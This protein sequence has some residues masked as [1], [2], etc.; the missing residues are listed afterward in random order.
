MYITEKSKLII[1]QLLDNLEPVT[2]TQIA[3]N[4]NI[5]P[6]SVRSYMKEVNKILNSLGYTLIKKPGVGVLLVGGKQARKEIYEKLPIEEAYNLNPVLRKNYIIETLL[7]NRYSYTIQLLADDLQV[8]KG[9]IIKDLAE[10]E[11]WLDKYRLKLIKKTNYGLSIEGSELDIRN[12]MG[13]FNENIL[14]CDKKDLKSG[15]YCDL[16][17]RI[18][19]ELFIKLKN[20]YPNIDIQKIIIIL[21]KAESLIGCSYTEN[22][23]FNLISQTSIAIE[24]VKFKKDFKIEEEKKVILK[25]KVEYGAA[26]WIVEQLNKEFGFNMSEEEACYLTIFML[27]SGI[28]VDLLNCEESLNL[29]EYKYKE[30]AYEIVQLVSSI[31]EINLVNNEILLKGLALH[32]KRVINRKKFNMH[33]KNPLLDQIKK[34]YTSIF[35][36]C[37]ATSNIFEKKTGLL[38][39]EDEV[40]FIA[41]HIGG[42]ISRKKNCINVIVV[43]AS[44]IGTS[45]L[46]AGR[47]ERYVQ[48]IIVK[49]V[50]PYNHLNEDIYNQA[51]LIISTVP[52]DNPEKNVV[53]I[54][55]KVNE[56]DIKKIQQVVFKILGSNIV[57][58][59]NE[60]VVNLIKEELIILDADCESIEDTIYYAS[61]NLYENGYVTSEFANDVIKREKITSTSVGKGV[62]IPH[63]I[64]G[65]V[66]KPGICLIKLKKPIEWHDERVDLVFVLALMFTDVKETKEFFKYFYYLL[67]NEKVLD[68]IR[69]SNDKKSILNIIM[70]QGE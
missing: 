36:A 68:D 3:E 34:E 18:N 64:K 25:E 33:L 30:L 44:G 63:S 11:K 65:F 21:K 17:Y 70:K 28:Q 47:I 56:A 27:G 48:E 51:E 58:K 29:L 10:V 1:R 24:R 59:S 46:I 55:S 6:R 43:C 23:F 31:L 22:D 62:A 2:M 4:L 60:S 53:I 52:I 54:S 16:D 13:Y 7:K 61:N 5:S 67:N 15:L 8:G 42:A 57:L 9:T 39:D 32:L 19:K 69:F 45:Q 26:L 66:I 14:N 40:A 37:W 49:D 38:L 20:M 50:L 12:A 41:I 35:G